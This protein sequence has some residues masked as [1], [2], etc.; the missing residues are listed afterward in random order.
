MKYILGTD[1]RQTQEVD[2]RPLVLLQLEQETNE[3]G[4]RNSKKS[5]DSPAGSGGAITLMTRGATGAA[6]AGAA[7]DEQDTALGDTLLLAALDN[8]GAVVAGDADDDE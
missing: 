2:A 1:S 6:R 8:D 4:I 5:V 7:D 3:D